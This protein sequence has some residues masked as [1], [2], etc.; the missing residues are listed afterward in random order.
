MPIPT[1]VLLLNRLFEYV[2]LV[3]FQYTVCP[4]SVPVGKAVP[5]SSVA[6]NGVLVSKSYFKT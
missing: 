4:V 1:L 2:Q 6:Q 3:P 5:V